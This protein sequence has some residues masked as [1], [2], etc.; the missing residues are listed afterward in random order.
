MRDSGP[1]EHQRDDLNRTTG[2]GEGKVF[3]K[4]APKYRLTSGGI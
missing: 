2:W 4:V 1:F 3:G